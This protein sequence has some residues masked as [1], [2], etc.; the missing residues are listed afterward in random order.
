MDFSLPVCVTHE[1]ARYVR[2]MLRTLKKETTEPFRDGV[3]MHGFPGAGKSPILYLLAGVAW[4]KEYFFVYIKDGDDWVEGGSPY[5]YFIQT[6]KRLN[7][8]EILKKPTNI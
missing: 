6:M 8:P 4:A 3:F 7:T 5:L 1:A 2:K